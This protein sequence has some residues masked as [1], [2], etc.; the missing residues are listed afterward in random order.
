MTSI[1]ERVQELAKSFL[2]DVIQIRRHLHQYPEMSFKEF[3]TAEFV[4]QQ[5]KDIGIPFEDGIAGTG[6]VAYIKGKNPDSKTMALRADL[7]ALPIVEANDVPYKSC[8]EG[9]MH[10]CGHDVHTASMIGAARILNT[11]K[12][13]FEGTVKLVFQP[14]EEQ[15]PGGASMMIAEGV[16]ENPRVEEMYG[17]HVFPDMEAGKVGFRKG[18]YMASCDEIYITIKGKGGHAALPHK[19]IDPIV[20]GANL[21]VS[22][23]QLVSRFIQPD[24]PAV[25]SFGDVRA[26]GATNIIPHEMKLKGTLR[27]LNEEW[28]DKAHSQLEKMCHS[29]VEAMGG[30]CELDIRKGYPYLENDE[31]L[32]EAAIQKAKAYMG[33]ENVIEL[34]LRMTAEDFAYYS[35]QVPSCFYRLGVQKPG[36]EKVRALHTP[37]FDVDE[38]SLEIGMGLMAWMVLGT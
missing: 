3:Q 15:L 14:G 20:I 4:K 18:M 26:V 6:I 36:T 25:L 24:V 22:L 34:P 7:D 21:I 9:V 31:E 37:E 13:S 17:Q 2:P 33:A 29:L 38:S 16:L 35:Q 19:L 5:L 8:N 28:R 32:T 12:D 1:K 10:A 11:L 23:Q 30:S 27:M